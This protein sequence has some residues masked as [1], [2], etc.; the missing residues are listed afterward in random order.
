MPA[1]PA[2][3]TRNR[4]GTFYFR[5]VVPL[6]LRSA[7]GFQ[8]EIRRSLKTDSQRL[9]LRRAR[10]FAARYEAA[11]DKVLTMVERDDYQITDEDIEAWAAEI[12]GAGSSEPWGSWSSPSTEQPEQSD[13]PI[14]DAERREDDEQQRRA[15]IAKVLT[16]S[17]KRTI[18]NHQQE[19]AGQL[20]DFGRSLPYRLFAKL[21]PERLKALALEQGRA[22]TPQPVNT[23]RPAEPAGPTL[24]ELWSL[25]WESESKLALASNKKPKPVRTKNAERAH[26]CRLNILS[27][28]KPISQLS[29]DDFNDI[30]LR[31]SQIKVSPGKKLP[32]PSAPIDSILAQAGERR[33]E[34]ATA[35]KIA[36]RLGVLHKFAHKRGLTTIPPDLPDK[37][38]FDQKQ[39]GAEPQERAFTKSDLESIFSGWLYTGLKVNH[40]QKVFPYQF[41]LPLLALYTGGRLNELCQLDTEDIREVSG[42]WTVTIVDDPTESPLPKSVKNDSSR[43]VLP[44]HTAL[45]KAGF[46][47]FWK[48]AVAEGRRKL[49]SD[50]LV[51]NIQKGWGGIATHFFC[52]MP[53]GSTPTGGYL[54]NVGVRKR[55]D[56]GRTDG[57]NF[58]S[59]RHTFVDLAR[60]AGA[61][62]YLVMPDL[63]GHSRKK[64]EG[65]WVDYG[66]GFSLEKKQLAIESLP[67]PFDLSN[68]TYADFER[69]LGSYLETWITRHRKEHGLNQAE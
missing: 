66:N 39:S 60:D 49:F 11:F 17:S 45:L 13:S 55:N 52:R 7:L 18:P 65:Q 33:I 12:E 59:F 32:D 43:R 42:I 47:D 48:Q 4:H 46:L 5:I 51:F 63:T 64:S 6:P 19:L 56:D 28:N 61:E 68:V 67:F 50:G 58:H 24:Y 29:L 26:A 9:A 1:Q 25:Q 16:G 37:P 14:T 40:R 38:S 35:D 34:P 69:R 41:W 23:A 54:F 44:L 2:Y 36:I 15:L 30:Y 57:K 10:Q 3:I 62:T 27:G 53:T 22:N 20:F 8:R 31:I 21:L